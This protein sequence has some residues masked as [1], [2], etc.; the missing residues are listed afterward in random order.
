VDDFIVSQESMVRRELRR[1]EKARR[2]ASEAKA[3]PEFNRPKT[4]SKTLSKT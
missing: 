3:A 1:K 4:L 2:R